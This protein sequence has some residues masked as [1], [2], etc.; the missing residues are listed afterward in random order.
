NYRVTV[1]GS[2]E[3]FAIRNLAGDPL[4]GT[5][6]SSFHTR[7]D[8]DPE[9]FEDQIPAVSPTVVATSPVDGAY[10]TSLAPGVAASVAV[11]QGNQVTIDFS[12]NVD[13]CTVNANTVL[14]Y[15]YATGAAGTMPNG[16]FPETDQ[17]PSDPFTWGSGNNTTP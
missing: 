7:L 12:E 1:I 8:T 3:E 6:S 16:F 17:T 11:H 9:L 2:P 15:Q 5:V 4:Q 10:P 13:P 14:F